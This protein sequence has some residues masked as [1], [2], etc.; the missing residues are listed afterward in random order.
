MGV[1]GGWWMEEVYY[2]SRLA[3]GFNISEKLTMAGLTF[4]YT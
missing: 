1:W 2:V 3:Q 4:S